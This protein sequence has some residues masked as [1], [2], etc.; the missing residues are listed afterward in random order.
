[1]VDDFW[2][3]KLNVQCVHPKKRA[4]AALWELRGFWEQ[5]DIGE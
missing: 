4:L 5:G 2:D 3:F 1:M